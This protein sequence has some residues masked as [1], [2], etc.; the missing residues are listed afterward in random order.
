MKMIRASVHIEFR[1]S[2]EID[3]PDNIWAEDIKAKLGDLESASFSEIL[4]TNKDIFAEVELFD[5]QNFCDRIAEILNE[6]CRILI[7]LKGECRLYHNKACFEG[8]RQDL[9]AKGY[10]TL[11]CGI[12]IERTHC[13]MPINDVHLKDFFINE[14]QCIN[15]N[16]KTYKKGW[17]ICFDKSCIQYKDFVDAICDKL[18]IWGF[19][20]FIDQDDSTFRDWFEYEY[21]VVE[22]KRDFSDDETAIMSSLSNGEGYKF[23]LD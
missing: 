12:T 2:L 23:G 14:M 16:V 21:K 8:T 13:R 15:V 19:R 20:L 5:Y 17:K 4:I 6:E 10:P 7:Y 22:A 3:Y 9:F 1:Y 11:H 18:N